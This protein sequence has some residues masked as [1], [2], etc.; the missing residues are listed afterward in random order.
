M[1]MPVSLTMNS[2]PSCHGAAGERDRAALRRELHRVGQQVDQHLL[3]RALVGVEHHRA[4]RQVDLH[5]EAML[6]RARA[7]QARD[8]VRDLVAIDLFHAQLEA[9]GFD[10]R[11]IE[12]VVDEAEQMLAAVADV[13]DVGDVALVAERTE[14]LAL[15]HLGEADDG[16]ERR[17]QFVADVGEELGLGAVGDDGLFPGLHQLVLVLLLRG[18]V[19]ADR[20]VAFVADRQA[21]HRQQAAVGAAVE[22]AARGFERLGIGRGLAEIVV[23]Q[24]LRAAVPGELVQHL[25]H[26]DA[27]AQEALR[28]LP[29]L[30]IGAV[31]VLQPA[32]AIPHRDAI[33]DRLDGGAEHLRGLAQRVVARFDHLDLL[34]R[35]AADRDDLP[36]HDQADRAQDDECHQCARCHRRHQRASGR[37]G[38]PGQ[39]AKLAAVAAHEGNFLAGARRRFRSAAPPDARLMAERWEGATM[40]GSLMP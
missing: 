13:A 15:H 2:T 28:E 19:A 33:L 12:D 24:A 36:E 25:V 32:L 40:R 35:H 8:A 6:D 38:R 20:H 16:V 26:G 22:P 14:Q 4:L 9:A 37:L 17:A 34:A 3:D 18:Q 1:P 39:L 7:N 23:L 11:Q 29:H 30:H 5:G 21:A 27:G 31:P 10:L